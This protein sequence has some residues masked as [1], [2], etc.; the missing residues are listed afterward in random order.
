MPIKVEITAKELNNLLNAEETQEY[1]Y[2]RLRTL[3]VPVANKNLDVYHGILE[4]W[5]NKSDQSLMF[6]W[7]EGSCGSLLLRTTPLSISTYNSISNR[8]EHDYDNF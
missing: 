7:R 2:L 8:W 3:G 5:S 1:V 4:S 6:L